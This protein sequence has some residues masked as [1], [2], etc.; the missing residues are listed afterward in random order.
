MKQIGKICWVKD[1]MA[2]IRVVRKGACG[3][4]CSMC[5]ACGGEIVE[6]NAKCDI[7]VV[8]GDMVE[9]ASDSS[10]VIFGMLSIFVLPVLLPLVTYLLLMERIGV[11]ASLIAGGVMLALCV[12][13]ICYLT[14]SKRYLAAAQ[15]SV[16][17]KLHE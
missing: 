2:K 5:G 12:L 4:H 14:K 3:E 1:G 10:A 16:I 7:E 11:F 8:A 9:I 17:C 6:I 15:A 13:F